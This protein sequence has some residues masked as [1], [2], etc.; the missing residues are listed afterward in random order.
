MGAW[1]LPSDLLGACRVLLRE[2]A[3]PQRVLPVEL[4]CRQAGLQIRSNF[5]LRYMSEY[6]KALS[7]SS[8]S[9]ARLKRI[10]QAPQEPTLPDPFSGNHSMRFITCAWASW[11]HS[12][13]MRNSAGGCSSRTP[14]HAPEPAVTG[15]RAPLCS[16]G[17][18]CP[19]HMPKHCHARL[20]PCSMSQ[21]TCEA[22]SA[23]DTQW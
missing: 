6:G 5:K 8:D 18:E 2:Q 11:R 22:P 14:H 19:R 1:R 23:A 12:A 17:W 9:N 15:G 7:S 3:R 10:N 4:T 21:C 13:S 16:A 20:K